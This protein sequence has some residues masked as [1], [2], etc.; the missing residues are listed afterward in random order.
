[1]ILMVKLNSDY[2]CYI[3]LEQLFILTVIT[4]VYF[5]QYLL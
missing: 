3:L 5:N 4:I 2:N 1:M